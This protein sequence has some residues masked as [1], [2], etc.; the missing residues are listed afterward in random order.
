VFPG[1]FALALA[2]SPLIVDA[3]SLPLPGSTWV[4]VAPADGVPDGWGLSVTQGSLR[5]A[6]GVEAGT[7][8][9]EWTAGTK[10]SL[11][12]ASAPVTPGATLQ[13]ST[14]VHGSATLADV[15]AVHLRIAG[16]RGDVHVA[17]RRFDTGA[18]PWEGVNITA[19]VPEGAT[20]AYVCFEV[21]MVSPDAAG[22]LEVTPLRLEELRATSTNPRLPVRRI[23]LV[24]IETLRWDHLSGNGYARATSP[25]LDRLMTEGVRFDAHYTPAPYTHPSLASLITGQWPTTLGFV[26][27]I[28]TLGAGQPTVA[29]LLAQAGYVTAA[30]NV[31]YVLSNR[32][33]LNRGFHYYR[34]H[35]NDTPAAVLNNELLPFLRAHADDNLFAW[36]HYFDPHGPYR[37]PA[38]YDRLFRGDALWNADARRLERGEAAEGAPAIPPY[39]F[40]KGMLERRHYVARYDGD[41]AYTDAELG[42]LVEALEADN[43]NDTLLIVTADHGESMT[44]HGRYFCHGSLYDHDLHVPFVVWGPGLVAPRAAP[45]GLSSHVDVVPTL[46]DYAGVGSLPGFAGQS[47]RPAIEGGAMPDR[48][49][50]MSVVGRSERLR[51]A[52][53]AP[54]GLKVVTSA[55]GAFESA[56]DVANDPGESKPV[57][58]APRRAGRA[59][60]REF[61]AW[62]KGNAPAG[63]KASTLDPEDIERLRALGYVE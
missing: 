35:P 6:R 55:R 18:F 27:N 24:S 44:D 21:Q 46:L 10:A 62:L 43:R 61:M 31:Q 20:G 8:R 54:G 11:C 57:S 5:V 60:A 48:P 17:R 1:L 4:D 30:F 40:D 13:F 12:S 39:V 25:T 16:A 14:R 26:D 15:T 2:Q 58:G 33:G 52:L 41:I 3:T 50:V 22:S 56:W 7:A 53:H 34:N 49:W 19:T 51:Y 23:V 63:R 42:R 37:P 38:G 45:A 36:V 28:P 29:D 47:L 32:Y 59:L 9:L